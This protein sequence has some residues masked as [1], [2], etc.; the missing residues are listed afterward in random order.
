MSIR[1]TKRI[2]LK[3]NYKSKSKGIIMNTIRTILIVFLLF[4]FSPAMELSDDEANKLYQEAYNL[5]LDKSWSEAIDK[6]EI[7]LD[8]YSDSSWEDDARFW[9]C[10]AHE[11]MDDDPEASFECL[12]GFVSSYQESKWR[13]DAI[14]NL[15]RLAKELEAEGKPEY[16]LRLNDIEDDMNDEL[17]LAAI[18]ALS[19]RGDKRAFETLVKLYDSSQSDNIRKKMVYIIGS[20]DNTASRDKLKDIAQNDPNEDIRGEA[21]FWLADDNATKDVADFLLK[22]AMNDKSLKVQKKA[23]FALGDMEDNFGI[24]Y[25]Y[26]VAKD[27]KNE[28][29][30]SEAV[31]WIGDNARTIESVKKLA[32][33]ALNDKSEKVRKKAIFALSESEMDTAVDELITIS[34]THRDPELRAVAIFWLSQHRVSAKKIQAIT[35][36]AYNDPDKKVQEKAVFALH[37]LEDDK[38]LDELINIAKNHKLVSIRKK[39]IFWL[40]ET[41]DERAVKALE[42]ILMT[43]KK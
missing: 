16:M 22:I 14:Q 25:L 4:Q 20:F 36:A 15:A 39:A 1:V 38:G 9:M 43:P 10:Y 3:K 26:K 12:E 27:H 24:P 37:E 13:N 31:F 28:D 35:E 29:L 7:L 23:V 6:F 41:D 5:V 18:Q 42:E 11:K 2:K 8:K 32:E 30:R 17:S 19:S 21:L 34:K 40:G 33:F